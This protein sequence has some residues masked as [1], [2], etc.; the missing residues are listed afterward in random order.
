MAARALLRADAAALAVVIVELV[1]LA[2][3]ELDDRAVRADAVAVVALHAV[4][5]G[6]AAPCLEDRVLL[7]QAMLHFVEVASAAGCLELRTH[8]LRSL[9]VVPRVHV[10]ELRVLVLGL[11]LVDG[12]LEVGVDGAGGVLAHADGVGHG[13]VA[14][15]AVAGC[16]DPLDGGLEGDRIDDQ[17]VLLELQ[18]LELLDRGLVDVLA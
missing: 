1:A 8:G 2:R 6:E 17:G 13:P 4:A 5:A 12:T 10:L 15:R 7:G 14:G 9:G 3:A 16:E 18:L 11:L